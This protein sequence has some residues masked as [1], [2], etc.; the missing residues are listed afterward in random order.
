M[1]KERNL[2]FQEVQQSELNA[3][4]HFPE[5]KTSFEATPVC[6]LPP[7]Y[8]VFAFFCNLPQTASDKLKTDNSRAW[9]WVKNFF[10]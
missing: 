10:S 1:L 2:R 7:K 3:K 9:K 8:K 6:S 5:S 4:A